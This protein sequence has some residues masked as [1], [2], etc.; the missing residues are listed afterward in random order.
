MKSEPASTDYLPVSADERWI[1]AA[2]S[3]HARLG[4]EG[5]DEE[6]ILRIL[7][8]TVH[9]PARTAAAVRPREWRTFAAASVAVAALVALLLVALSSFPVDTP[10]RRSDELRFVVRVVEPATGATAAAAPSNPRVAAVPHAGPVEV[11]APGVS[12]SSTLTVPANESLELVTEFGPTFA[13]LPRQTVRDETLRITA[14]RGISADDAITYEGDVVVEHALF[15]IEAASVR[16]PAPGG[17]PREAAPRE[18]APLQ[19]RGV[20][21]VQP[22]IDCIAEADSLRFDPL[23]GQ[24]VLTGV[25]RV[26]TERGELARF[27]PGDQLVLSANGFSVET[28]P[29]ER[30]ADPVLRTR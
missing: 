12:S 8:E 27:A 1:D 14:D 13:S 20:R 25:R 16:V 5:A 4:N 29:V 7:Q 28:A 11:T 9:R 10:L 19:A 26:E 24:L 3:E 18:A 15:R 22:G 23:S 2:L 6:L 21:V 30:Y 17:T